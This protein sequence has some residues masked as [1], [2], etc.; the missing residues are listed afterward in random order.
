MEW[1]NL[2][3]MANAMT[4][5]PWVFFTFYIYLTFYNTL[6]CF[7][8]S[9]IM[10]YLYFIRWISTN[11]FIYIF[12]QREQFHSLFL[13][14]CY[15]LSGLSCIFIY[16]L[17]FT[18][19]WSL[20][21]LSFTFFGV[22]YLSIGIL[23]ESVILKSWGDYRMYFYGHHRT[24]S[25]WTLFFLLGLIGL[26]CYFFNNGKKD[27]EQ[28]SYLFSLLFTIMVCVGTL[29]QCIIA[30][31]KTYSFPSDPS[32]LG[33]TPSTPWLQKNMT[34]TLPPSDFMF[35]PSQF[36]PYKPYS[37][38]GEPLS[39]ISEEDASIVQRITSTPSTILLDRELS[40]HSHSSSIYSIS[41]SNNNSSPKIRPIYSNH[42]NHPPPFNHHSTSY[43]AIYSSTP[44][45]LSNDHPF[46]NNPLFNNNNNSNDLDD[47]RPSNA[48][49]TYDP[50]VI[51][52][53]NNNNNNNNDD[54]DYHSSFLFQQQ[55]I[56]SSSIHPHWESVP[57]YE[58]ALFSFIPPEIPSIAI[59]PI[60][61]SYLFLSSNSDST[62]IKSDSN[63]NQHHRSSSSSQQQYHHHS[64]F[65]KTNKNNNVIPSL[66]GPL[67]INP[68]PID[69]WKI[70]SLQLNMFIL[71]C[72]SALMH[73]FL[74]IYFYAVLKI[75]IFFI[76][77]SGSMIFLSELILLTTVRK[78][79]HN[80]HY[81]FMAILI[82]SVLITC[83]IAYLWIIPNNYFTIIASLLLPFLQGIIFY[84]AWL[85]TSN[86]I[87]TLVWSDQQRM[88]QRS[89]MSTLFS[90]IGP[91][92]G[93]I[94][95]GILVEDNNMTLKS[96][97]FSF[98]YQLCVG[99]L[100]FSF[101]LSWAWCEEE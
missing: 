49:F 69:K 92:V 26:I 5:A 65:N 60:L 61:L 13:S 14:T 19:H 35:W 96:T 54:D 16:R 36:A 27:N 67:L 68:P 15:I 23:I 73:V 82:H 48:S 6:T 70:I 55:Q 33:L 56:Y 72:V 77:F 44:N 89:I 81:T 83:S 3:A 90:C 40:H 37:L 57:S 1:S 58:L 88:V 28:L 84:L 66:P 87:N 34:T 12:D 20:L 47:R 101:V 9:L 51:L 100:A 2:L 24:W 41:T 79:I 95:A 11:I 62:S 74:F 50:P 46:L 39:H 91:I 97:S 18:L 93:T 76:C 63:M 78:W 98:I 42:N 86:R 22:F 4:G 43:G 29:I 17:Q 10:A 38:F 8:I 64:T 25:E 71:G 53:N 31:L 45:M 99:L 59:F 7:Q 85:V 30:T 52:T 21:L 32:H 75:P 94:L 80:I